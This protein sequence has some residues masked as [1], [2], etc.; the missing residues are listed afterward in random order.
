MEEAAGGA[1]LR[2][3]K[4]VTNR[5]EGIGN[6]RILQGLVNSPPELPSLNEIL[7]TSVRP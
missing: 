7:H 6:S 4:G 5:T 1:P 3:L 2:R